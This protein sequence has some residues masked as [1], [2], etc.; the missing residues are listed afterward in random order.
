MSDAP[1]VSVYAGLCCLGFI[2][3]RGAAGFILS[4]AQNDAP[5]PEMRP[6]TITSPISGRRNT[7]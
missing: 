7:V 5:L 6:C 2:L 3:N 4:P 1:M